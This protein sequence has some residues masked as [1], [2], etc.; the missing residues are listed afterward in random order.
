LPCNAAHIANAVRSHW[1]IENS[2]HWVLDVSFHEDASRI[3]KDNAPENMAV[4]RHFALNLISRDKS[5]KSSMAAKRKKTAW[6]QDYLY[7]LLS[8]WYFY[9]IALIELVIA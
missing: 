5:S 1:S 2:L 4:L 6:D 9:V 7:K 3:R 8:L